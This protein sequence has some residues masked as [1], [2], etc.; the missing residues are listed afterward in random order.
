MTDMTDATKTMA[1]R[2]TTMVNCFDDAVLGLMHI[3][4]AR[5]I[6]RMPAELSGMTFTADVFR[7]FVDP[8][9]LL[10]RRY[11]VK[12]E[13]LFRD[14]TITNNLVLEYG[15]D[16]NLD[17]VNLDVATRVSRLLH[18]MSH[19]LAVDMD[20]MVIESPQSFDNDEP[21]AVAMREAYV[22][23]LKAADEACD[24]EVCALQATMIAMVKQFEADQYNEQI[25]QRPLVNAF[26]NIVKLVD[27]HKIFVP[28][29]KAMPHI[30][31]L[32]DQRIN[33]D[34]IGMSGSSAIA[35]SSLLE[36]LS[37]VVDDVVKI[38]KETPTVN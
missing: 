5:Y 18:T 8:E 15:L 20:L 10:E 17:L 38:A 21:A 28:L 23:A 24:C 7:E 27:K 26:V 12:F 3:G 25:M 2:F 11:S 36:L 31:V 13:M 9:T 4:I 16:Y 6:A 1:L 35:A 19:E 37:M 29:D 33:I 34:E 22:A 14:Q 30:N 32:T